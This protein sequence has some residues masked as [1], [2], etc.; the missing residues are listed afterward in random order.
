[1]KRN[2]SILLALFCIY[3]VSFG[4]IVKTKM[5]DNGGSG[6]YKAIASTEKSLPDFV[7]YRPEN[8]KK[9]VKEEEKLPV[10]VWEI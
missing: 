4:Q 2:T 7:V 10:L 6:Q 3:T 9:A 1:M 5:I 8:I